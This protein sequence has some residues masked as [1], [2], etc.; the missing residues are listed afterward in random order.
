MSWLAGPLTILAFA[1][2]AALAARAAR[3]TG[4]GV[5]HPAVAWLVLEG[6]F[7]GIGSVGLALDGRPGPGLFV[8]ASV[9]A[10]GLAV[11]ASDRL[12]ESRAEPTR[13]GPGEGPV[14]DDAVA[15]PDPSPVR[16]RWPWA[17][18]SPRRRRSCPP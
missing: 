11:A 15:D 2:G 16:I 8:A 12:A 4:L 1:A 13:E 3:R 9:V 14:G 6:V 7:F 17:S 5:W 18:P 10:L